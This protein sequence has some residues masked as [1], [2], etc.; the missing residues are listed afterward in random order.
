[1][2]LQLLFA[3]SSGPPPRRERRL[4]YAVTT[5]EEFRQLI[6]PLVKNRDQVGLEWALYDLLHGKSPFGHGILRDITVQW[7][8]EIVGEQSPEVQQFWQEDDST[9]M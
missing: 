5:K 2:T 7:V 6:E 3:S 1:M 8:S 9:V 4:E